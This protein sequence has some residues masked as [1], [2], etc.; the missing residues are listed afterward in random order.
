MPTRAIRPRCGRVPLFRGHGCARAAS[1]D[2]YV[3]NPGLAGL[4]H[5]GASPSRI[6]GAAGEAHRA[7]APAGTPLE[8]P[9]AWALHFVSFGKVFA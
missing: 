8:P 1:A 7:R 2:L 3:Q 6:A 9:S 4:R 5:L